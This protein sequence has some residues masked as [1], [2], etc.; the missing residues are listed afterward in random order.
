MARSAWLVLA[1]VT[2][3]AVVG[4]A[5]QAQSTQA[6]PVAHA[7]DNEV[8]DVAAPAPPAGTGGNVVVDG[9]ARFTALTD[10][11]LR[12]EYNAAGQFSNSHR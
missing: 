5:I 2:L 10:R 8:T 1:G 12:I 11:T 9:M 6:A 4:T 7:D 3:L